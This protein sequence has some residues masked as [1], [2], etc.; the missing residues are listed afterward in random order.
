LANLCRESE[1][2]FKNGR[3]TGKIMKNI[4]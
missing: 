1:M 3:K 4:F 2:F